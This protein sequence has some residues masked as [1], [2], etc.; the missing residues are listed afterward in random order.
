MVKNVYCSTCELR[1][2]FYL[3]IYCLF[4]QSQASFCRLWI[5]QKVY[6]CWI[7]YL[8][9]IVVWD[10]PKYIDQCKSVLIF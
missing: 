4:I 1:S 3:T 10:H 6:G 5:T 9:L 2:L 7:N 8:N